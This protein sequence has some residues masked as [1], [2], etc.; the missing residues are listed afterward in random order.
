MNKTSENAK[1][2]EAKEIETGA[3][4]AKRIEDA[5]EEIVTAM[6]GRAKDAAERVKD[7]GG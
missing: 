2:L 5:T 7:A 1:E 4:G 6:Q 3:E